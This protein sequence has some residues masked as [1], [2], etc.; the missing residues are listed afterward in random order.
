MSND[1]EKRT[2]LLDG[3]WGWM[4]TLGGFLIL[5]CHGGFLT[6]NAMIFTEQRDI[7]QSGAEKLAWASSINGLCKFLLSK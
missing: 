2:N 3:G 6:A 5:L 4:V 7:F 1:S